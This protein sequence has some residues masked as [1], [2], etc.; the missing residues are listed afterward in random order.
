MARLDRTTTAE[1]K[2]PGLETDGPSLPATLTVGV[3]TLLSAI[4]FVVSAFVSVTGDSQALPSDVHGAATSSEALASPQRRAPE[5]RPLE[6]GH[7][8]SAA[9]SALDLAPARGASPVAECEATPETLFRALTDIG[10]VLLEARPESAPASTGA[11]PLAPAQV[12]PAGDRGRKLRV[13]VVER[14]T[15]PA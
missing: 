14:T 9:A 3:A 12:A 10:E 7:T 15:A 6:L 11:C 8:S 13:H 4:A 2:T 1:S 5:M